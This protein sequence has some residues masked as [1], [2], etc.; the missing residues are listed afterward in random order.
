MNCR[1]KLISKKDEELGL[2]SQTI[3]KELKTYS[4]ALQQ[5]CLTALSP[6]NIELAVETIIKEKDRTKEVVVFGVEEETDECVTTKVSSILKQL[7][8]KPRI[9]ACRRIGQRATGESKKRLIIFSVKSTD[10]V[11][12]MMSESA[13]RNWLMS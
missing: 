10:I 5:S 6:K 8:E 7:D 4:S 11:Y 9:T 3:Q 12:Q 13:A 2:V 1:K